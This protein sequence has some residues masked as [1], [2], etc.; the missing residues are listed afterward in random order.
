MSSWALGTL[1][2]P[3]DN[4]LL[5]TAIQPIKGRNTLENAIRQA[6]SSIQTED[7]MVEAMRDLVKDEIKRYIRT[8]LDENPEIKR[9][10]NEA[11]RELMDAKAREYYAL[12][13]LAKNGVEL[14]MEMMPPEMRERLSRDIASLIEKEM[15]QVFEKM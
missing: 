7:L 5:P 3:D 2:P 9:Q 8:K 13:R 10:M 12:A 15:N 1:G 4:I 11:V 6:L 14:G